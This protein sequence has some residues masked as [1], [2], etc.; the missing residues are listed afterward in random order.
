MGVQRRWLRKEEWG[1][2]RP[3]LAIPLARTRVSP[4][5]KPCLGLG[6]DFNLQYGAFQCSEE[7]NAERAWGLGNFQLCST[8]WKKPRE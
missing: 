5:F 7:D 4:G 6:A 2:E 3:E 1:W 8:T